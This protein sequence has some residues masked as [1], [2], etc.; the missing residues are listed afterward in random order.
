MCNSWEC[1][2][3]YILGAFTHTCKLWVSAPLYQLR[4]G[5]VF[6]ARIEIVIHLYKITGTLVE[7]DIH[8]TSMISSKLKTC[9]VYILYIGPI[10]VPLLLPWIS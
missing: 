10:V 7:F 9:S 2:I 8:C 3:L 4:I 5:K 6:R 1:A